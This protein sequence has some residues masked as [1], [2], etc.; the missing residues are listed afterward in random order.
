MNSL[1]KAY[2]YVGGSG[3]GGVRNSTAVRSGGFNGGGSVTP[4]NN[5]SYS[6]GSGAGATDI[7]LNEDSLYSRVIVAGGGGGIADGQAGNTSYRYQGC[8]GGTSGLVGYP[9]NGGQPGT[10]TSGYSFGA[11]GNNVPNSHGAA[12]GGGWYGGYN[13]P[14]NCGGGGGSG[15]VYTSSTKSQYPSQGKLNDSYLLTSAQTTAGNQS[16]PSTSSGNE[17]GHTGNGYARITRSK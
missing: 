7:R 14:S 4:P 15:Y 8:G 1:T 9:P 10:P 5:D 13:S 2:L 11:G 12:G 16:F 6:P 17:T 3:K